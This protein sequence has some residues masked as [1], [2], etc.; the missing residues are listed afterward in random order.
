[1]SQTE[2]LP[3]P[4]DTVKQDWVNLGGDQIEA[5]IR[6]AKPEFQDHLRWYARFSL[7]T[8][9]MSFSDMGRELNV[10]GS[11]VSRVYS[12]KY[13]VNG[14]PLPPPAK[15]MSRIRILRQ[16]E[17]ERSRRKSAGF[18]ET[19][20]AT[21]IFNICRKAWNDRLIAMIFGMSHIGKTAALKRFRDEN[22]HG[23]TLY[24]DLQGLSGVQD[25]Y[26]EFA[27][28]LAI[29]PNTPINKLKP[30][31]HAAIDE[32]N[33]VLVD[34]FHFITYAYQR[35]SAARMVSEIKSIKDRSGC[36]M[37]ICA[38]DVGR[39]EFEN[40]REKKL[41]EQ[42]WRRGTLKLQLPKALRVG[43]VRAI[44]HA[45]G[46]DL[47]DAP[48]KGKDTWKRLRQ[49]HP[50]LDQLDVLE[51]IAYNQGIQSLVT[52][53]QDGNVRASR[54]SRDLRWEDV[55]AVQA[56]YAAQKKHKEV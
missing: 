56:I 49:E 37:V 20:T 6:K 50:E 48:T 9:Q 44:C 32:T 17:L 38:T 52:T 5:G 13:I 39:E 28:A 4:P 46:L 30:R 24:I 19:P 43:D 35:G 10:D 42:L 34:E 55:I 40:G 29:S 41:M 7:V 26:R 12:G 1:M 31:V 2:Q 45:Y 27:R 54:A 25:I 8:R 15:M 51:D 36:G 16:Q 33:L 18:I 21:D 11:T 14:I 22:N 23:A 53:L 47:P 3:T